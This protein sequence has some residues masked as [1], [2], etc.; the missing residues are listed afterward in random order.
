MGLFGVMRTGVS[1]MNAQSSK[2]GTVADNIANSST[3]GY[4]RAMTE[5]SSL[6]LSQGSG[7]YNSGGVKAHTKY[8][9]TDQ[10]AR[11]YTTSSLDLAVS[12]NGFFIVSSGTDASSQQALTRAGSFVPDGEGFLVNTAGYYLQG[13][14]I[15]D[16]SEPALVANGLGGLEP[17]NIS[18]NKLEATPTGRATLYTNVSEDATIVAGANLPSVDFASAATVDYSHKTSLIVYDNLGN[19]VKL[20]VYYSKTSEVPPASDWEVAV[21]D[22][23]DST[24]GGF[25]YANPPLSTQTLTFDTTTGDLA[26]A[27]PTTINVAVPNGGTFDIDLA[28]STYLN[29]DF[30]VTT[31]DTDGNAPSSVE[32]V[33]FNDDGTLFAVYENGDRRALYKIPLADVASPDKLDPLSGNIYRPSFESGEVR[34]GFPGEAG[35]GDLEVGALESSNVDLAS[36]LTSMIESQRTYTANSQVFKAGSD[37]LQELV[38][39]T[40]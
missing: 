20:D 14:P 38:N 19:E 24:N 39:L 13:Y 35:L 2:L 28:D 27:S 15:T 6:V 3:T 21:F 11:T 12:G 26:G 18:Q 1:G 25:P 7:T 17:I 40:R 36:E 23:A 16:G 31:V 30:E 4:K 5:F 37:L 33:E 9:I 29:A 34:V 10:G 22:S 8:A 32:G